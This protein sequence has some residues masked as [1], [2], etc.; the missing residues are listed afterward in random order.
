MLYMLTK[1]RKQSD[2]NYIVVWRLAIP[3]I[4]DQ[5]KIIQWTFSQNVSFRLNTLL[6]GALQLLVR[7]YLSMKLRVVVYGSFLR[8]PVY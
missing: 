1:L 4:N 6:Y 5:C 3:Y 2:F 7:Y 8:K